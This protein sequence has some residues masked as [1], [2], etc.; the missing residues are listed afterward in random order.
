MRLRRTLPIRQRL[1][2]YY[3]TVLAL[4]LVGLGIFLV[5]SL[6]A[7]LRDRA[8][9]SLEAAY[10]PLALRLA[11]AQ[12]VPDLARY[13]HGD[14][15]VNES[16][17]EVV[18][19]ILDASGRVRL[20]SGDPGTARPMVGRGVLVRARR[21]GHWHEPRHLAGRTSEDIVVV[22]PIH[23]GVLNGSF[24]VFAQTLRSVDDAV[25]RLILL[26]G[27]ATPVALALALFGG[28]RIAR[29][30]LDPVDDMTRTAAA[31]D[32]GHAGERLRE[33]PRDDELGRLART[34]NAML[35]RLDRALARERRFAAD[36]SHEMRTPLA[37]MAAE[38]DVAL[39]R[40]GDVA[41]ARAV[42]ESVRE[43]V[44]RLSRMVE[45]LLVVSRADSVAGVELA[46]RDTD[47]LDLAVGVVSRLQPLAAARHVEIGLDGTPVH[48]A[49]DPELLAHGLANLVENAIKYGDAHGPVTVRVLDGDEPRIEVT[50]R[51]PGIAPED[52]A[53]VF[54]RFS[55]LDRAR[56][57]ESGGAGLGLAITRAVVE[58]HG[59]RVEVASRLG[60]GTTFTIVLARDARRPAP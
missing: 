21:T 59:G 48:V 20:T 49:A 41:D 58:A 3:A 54:E 34:L 5:L 2:L 57:R 31:I 19:Q 28:S 26:L 60:E 39:H 4:I 7:G 29:L 10:R 8:H 38:L 16:S 37:L 47:L 51:G 33:P 56:G 55:R 17:L 6:R 46:R 32:A 45:N 23:G 9:D 53:H 25:T 12:Q 40:P 22:V 13:L 11:E 30:A 24:A 44:G 35:D 1:T 36:A 52:L 50:D 43:E 15:I 18:G 42:L 14:Q 27:L